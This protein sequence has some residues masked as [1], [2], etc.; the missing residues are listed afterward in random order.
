[1]VSEH[2]IDDREC[3][4]LGG[5]VVKL[6]PPAPCAIVAAN[7]SGRPGHCNFLPV[8]SS[9]ALLPLLV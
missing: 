8:A 6:L 3:L 9:E 2:F 5:V 7:Q 4:T 1:M